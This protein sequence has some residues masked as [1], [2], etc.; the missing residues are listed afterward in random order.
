MQ[1]I[2]ADLHVLQPMRIVKRARNPVD[3]FNEF[4][5]FD[6]VGCEKPSAAEHEEAGCAPLIHIVNIG[7]FL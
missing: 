6:R 2:V 1:E 4:V 5:C 3:S 7:G